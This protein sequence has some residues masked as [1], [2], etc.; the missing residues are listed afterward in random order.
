MDCRTNSLLGSFLVFLSTLPLAGT[1][2]SGQEHTG[3]CLGSSIPV[4]T[5][6][7]ERI[8]R[9]TEAVVEEGRAF[10]EAERPLILAQGWADE[11][12]SPN[13]Y[14]SFL[15]SV[16]GLAALPASDRASHPI[17]RMTD[18]II[19]RQAEWQ[20]RAIPHLCS[21]F[22]QEVDL[23]RPAFFVAFIPPR[24]FATS[25][26]IVIDVAAD[27]WN[28][29]SGNILNM[30]IHEFF[31]VGYGQLRP[32][33]TDT[34]LENG[35]LNSMVE[36]I[37]NEGMAVWVAYEARHAFP[38]PG[39]VDN[40]LLESP[41]DVADLRTALNDLFERSSTISD[42]QLRRQGWRVG[43]TNRAYYIVGAYI[44]R[45]IQAERGKTALVGTLAN[46]PLSYIRLYNSLVPE[47]ER[48]RVPGLTP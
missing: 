24:A 39:E 34:P 46:G 8:V 33:R 30:M 23:S 47:E 16:E 1:P 9:E 21:F 15:A 2:A 35:R 44:A 45:V 41:E 27:Y 19:A 40:R 6:T 10:W 37:Q 28:G 38:A 36:S 17:A 29:D 43:V 12:R 4:E 32:H 5:S 25:E 42:D 18:E 7:L 22:P 31:H 14:D 20:E 26:G 11:V 13:P 3:S 48:V